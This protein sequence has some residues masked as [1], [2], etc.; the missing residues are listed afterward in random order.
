MKTLEELYCEANKCT[1]EEFSGKVFWQCLYRHAW[2]FVPFLMLLNS[3]YFDADKEMIREI[4]NARKMSQVWEEVRAYFVNP[5]HVG[6]MRRR[7]N[8][9][10]SARRVI[11]LAREYLPSTGSPPQPYPPQTESSDY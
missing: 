9:R 4:R 2:P 3:K 1:P 7:A 5:R 6:W 8:I 11:N 10:L